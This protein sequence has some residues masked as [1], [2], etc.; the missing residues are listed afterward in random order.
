[1]I[2]CVE[3]VDWYVLPLFVASFRSHTSTPPQTNHHK[4][5]KRFRDIVALHRPDYVRAPKVQKPSV[6]RVIVRAIRNGDPP[7]RFL[8][9]DEKTGCWVDIGDKK[10][11]EKT[12]QALREKTSEEREKIKACPLLQNPSAYLTPGGLFTAVDA[13]TA[14]TVEAAG[15]AAATVDAAGVPQANLGVPGVTTPVLATAPEA[16][17][18]AV[19][20]AS[21]IIATNMADGKEES[22]AP[23]TST[24]TEVA[25]A[26][27]VI[28]AKAETKDGEQLAVMEVDYSK[29]NS[30]KEAAQEDTTTMDPLQQEELPEAPPEEEQLKPK[31]NGTLPEDEELKPVPDESL[32]PAED[33]EDA[34]GGWV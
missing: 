11:T 10:A 33:V 5:N 13:A 16:V 20:A 21:T 31:E 24:A 6:A 14:A 22:A 28:D 2:S 4:G 25:N 19:A 8:R 27:A 26:M 15:V 23:T 3:E 17:A 34:L 32:A 1:M 12:S 30:A 9:K 7:G 29:E 18:V